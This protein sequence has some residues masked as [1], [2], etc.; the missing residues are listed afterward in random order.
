MPYLIQSSGDGPD[1]PVF[2]LDID[3]EAHRLVLEGVPVPQYIVPKMIRLRTNH[4]RL[5]DFTEF[6]AGCYGVSDRAKCLIER[7]APAQSEAVPV[8]ILDKK[9]KPMP[10]DFYWLN[11]PQKHSSII[12]GRGN[13]PLIAT[14]IPSVPGA[15]SPIP[16]LHLEL[17]D[18]DDL[19]FDPSKLHPGSQLWHEEFGG[20]GYSDLLFCSDEMKNAITAQKL[21]GFRFWK[22]KE[23]RQ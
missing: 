12:L 1:V 21:T 15:G 8:Q 22:L 4:K 20:Y 5:K 6:I 18:P 16:S 10:V 19:Y 17:Y 11:V 23:A 13:A 2:D 3:D 14:E 7:V 9:R